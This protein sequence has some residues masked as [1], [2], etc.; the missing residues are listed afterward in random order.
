MN[1]IRQ[2]QALNK[3]EIEQGIPPEASWHR[4]FDDTAWLYIGG[5]AFDLTEGDIITIFSQ[6]GEPV[7]INLVRDKETGKSRGFAF[8]KYEDQRSTD[9]AVDNLGGA[10]VL[11]RLLRVDHTRYKLKED[12]VVTDRIGPGA[13]AGAGAGGGASPRREG[14]K[15]DEMMDSSE[16]RRRLMLRPEEDRRT[17]RHEHDDDDPM[18]EYLIEQKRAESEAAVAVALLEKKDRRRSE[19]G[20]AGRASPAPHSAAHEIPLKVP[21]EDGRGGREGK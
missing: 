2:I 18:R 21:A 14:R 17:R 15:T 16:D 11:G 5:L 12:E 9:L 20:A 19:D 13:G 4:E 3:R 6:F 8:L 1:N 10:T 7:H